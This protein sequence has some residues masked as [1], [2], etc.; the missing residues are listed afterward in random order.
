MMC[1]ICSDSNEKTS[2]NVKEMMFGL[3]EVFIYY[4]CRNCECLQIADIPLNLDKY[5]S[6]EYY[7]LV[8]NPQD[9]FKGKIRKWLKG[10]R[11]YFIITKKGIAGK[12]IQL[13]L[14][15]SSQEWFNFRSISLN[16]SSRILDVGS[17]TG[18]IPFIFYNAGFK[19]IIGIDPYLSDDIFYSNGLQIKKLSLFEVDN[20][21]WDMVMFNHSFEHVPNPIEYLQKVH[22]LLKSE[23]ICVLRIPTVSSFAWENYKTEWVQLDAPRHLFLHSI[24]SIRHMA[25][26]TGFSVDK[27]N[28]ESSDFQF[29]GSEQYKMDIS[30]FGEEKSYFRGNKTL[31]SKEQLDDF[32]KR[33][34]KLNKELQGDSISVILRK[35]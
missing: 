4:Q 7:S 15:N 1:R 12:Y 18:T 2:Y 19:N 17:G 9:F 16:K 20:N 32:K 28:Y 21:G 11:D 25:K 29:I 3:R 24:S 8:M 35:K 14:P 31:F 30:L 13:L 5:Y 33:A 6:K 22:S 26:V 10:K 34:K 23:G 27:I